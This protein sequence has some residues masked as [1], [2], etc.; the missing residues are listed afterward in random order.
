M[1]TSYL[2]PPLNLPSEGEVRAEY[3]VGMLATNP[4]L[5][6]N[7]TAA[8]ISGR[9]GN[10]LT[11]PNDGFA[12]GIVSPLSAK[13]TAAVMAAGNGLVG[14]AVSLAESKIAGVW[15]GLTARGAEVKDI[16]STLSASQQDKTGSS[17]NNVSL[18]AS[19]TN[20]GSAVEKSGEDRTHLITLQNTTDPTSIIEFVVMPEIVENRSVSYEPVQ[21][22]QFPGAFQK[23][24]GTESVQWQINATFVSRTS[25][26][27]SLNLKYLS[28]LR[29]W[30]MPF[31]G[32]AIK[33]SKFQSR[34]GA[35]PPVLKFKG[36]R[37]L[38]GEVPVVI[39]S[40]SW[41]WPKDVD[42]IEA[43][44]PDGS[45]TNI[46]FPTVMQVSIQIVESF[47]TEQFNN[48]SLEKYLAGNISDAYL[49]SKDE[50]YGNEGHG[51]SLQ[52]TEEAQTI[53]ATGAGARA[54]RAVDNAAAPL[55]PSVQ[56]IV[57]AGARNE[58]LTQYPAVSLKAD[59]VKSAKGI[60]QGPTPSGL[61]RGST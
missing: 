13:G 60:A 17:G 40:L 55:L 44:S 28:W 23:Y 6:F 8:A 38:L 58:Q 32:E 48:F 49:P 34:L 53:G 61:R 59:E 39:N 7:E 29:A 14:N 27:A 2:V 1:S 21:P 4:D 3:D 18:T 11:A 46:P 30:T 12:S 25:D 51:R 9:F 47:S 5:K 20:A 19:Q 52:T 41:N 57:R 31:Y 33:S 45:K 36:Y 50:N 56:D 43:K 22:V 16:A 54:A 15:N 42:Y 10:L 35:P 37:G 24:K 26:E